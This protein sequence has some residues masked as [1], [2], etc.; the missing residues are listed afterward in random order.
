M[1]SLVVEDDFTERILLT[2][3]LKSYGECDNAHDGKA[4]LK[5]VSRAVEMGAYYD[6]ICLDIVMPEVDGHTTL[7]G[8]RRIEAEKKVPSTKAAKIIMVTALTDR[9][10]F[11]AAMGAN[12][13][14]YIRKPVRLEMLLEELKNMKLIK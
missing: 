12:C 8:I 4:A 5:M 9:K 7:A 1:R 3:F 13:D 6:L 14:G 11:F 10:N 2:E